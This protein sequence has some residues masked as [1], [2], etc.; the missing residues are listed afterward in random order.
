[1]DETRIMNRSAAL[2]H[3]PRLMN[4]A[5]TDLCESRLNA[6]KISNEL[7]GEPRSKPSCDDKQ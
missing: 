7:K 2:R 1:M 4:D 5:K 6:R 3:G